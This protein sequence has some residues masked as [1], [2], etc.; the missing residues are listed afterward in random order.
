MYMTKRTGPSLR[1]DCRHHFRCD[2]HLRVDG[3][4]SP[5]I[6]GLNLVGRPSVT[7]IRSPAR[8]LQRHMHIAGEEFR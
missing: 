8:V 4:V 1:W 2:R 5:C 6:G 3:A 7:L